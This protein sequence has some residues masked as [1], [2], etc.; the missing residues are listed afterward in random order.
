M[1]RLRTLAASS[2][3]PSRPCLA[4]AQPIDR[5]ALVSR[6]DPSLTAVDPH[7]PMMVGNGELAFT[8][9]ITGLQT[10]PEQ[11]SPLAPLLTMAQWSWHSFPNPKGYTEADGLTSG[12]RAR[13]RPQPYAWMKGGLE[14]PNPADAWLRENPHHFSLGRIALDLRDAGGAR[15]PSPTCPRPARPWTC[16]P[17][18]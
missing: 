9:D 4:L 3:W 18:P 14:K 6:H 2:P 13:P 15:P 12:R 7:A 10:F 5:H 11:Y 17:A 1:I 8:A 16:G